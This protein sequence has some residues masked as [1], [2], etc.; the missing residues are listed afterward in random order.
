MA[1]VDVESGGGGKRRNGNFEINMIPM[2]DLLMVTISFLLITAV[3]TQ[4]SRLEATAQV[5]GPARPCEDGDCCGSNCPQEKKLHV[6]T[7]DG[8][9]FL[10]EWRQGRSVVSTSELQID[11]PRSA[12]ASGLERYPE[13]SNAIGKEWQTSGTHRDKGDGAFDHAVIHAS[14]DLPY[15]T[16]VG[17]MDA[18]SAPKRAAGKNTSASAFEVSFAMD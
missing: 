7:I 17:V 2:I 16:L 13:L 8:H 5:P 14:N 10:L 15:A 1:G 6:T 11:A 12:N 18:V 9:K 4:M 3:W